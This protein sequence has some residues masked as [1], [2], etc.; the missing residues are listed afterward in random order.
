MQNLLNKTNRFY[1]FLQTKYPCS[2]P[3]DL[4][5]YKTTTWPD[6]TGEIRKYT[7]DT[8][9]ILVVQG[10]QTQKQTLFTLAH[11]YGHALQFDRK[12]VFDRTGY[13]NVDWAKEIEANNFAEK[14]TQ[15]YKSW[16]GN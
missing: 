8:L 13:N 1:K 14:V 7:N 11:E 16:R 12:E 10:K 15:E 4:R 5:V 9:M 3:I 2:M 6:F